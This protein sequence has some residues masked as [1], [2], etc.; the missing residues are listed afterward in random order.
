MVDQNTHIRHVSGFIDKETCRML[1]EHAKSHDEDFIAYGNNEKQFMVYRGFEIRRTS[2]ILDD[3]ILRLGH[4]VYSYI[5]KEYAPMKFS[6]AIKQENQIARFTEG[7]GMHEHFDSSRPK[8][9]ATLIYLNDDY[10][11]GEIYFP[12]YGIEIKPKVG[13]LICFPDNPEYVHGV[14]PIVSGSRYTSPRWFTSIV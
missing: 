13:D 4:L 5:T 7:V 11:G 12:K 14:R 10:I 2:T 1:Y 6:N 8:D 3:E 9:Y